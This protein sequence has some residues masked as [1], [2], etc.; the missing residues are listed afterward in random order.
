MGEMGWFCGLDWRKCYVLFDRFF[1]D[2]FFLGKMN[3]MEV[4]WI[5]CFCLLIDN[6]CGFVGKRLKWKYVGLKFLVMYLVFI[7]RF[8]VC[9]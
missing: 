8:I 1:V 6:C 5:Y 4:V 3:V 9:V 7:N 2:L